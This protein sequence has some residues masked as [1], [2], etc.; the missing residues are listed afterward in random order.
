MRSS[1]S[2]LTLFD[3]AIY[4]IRVLGPLDVSWSEQLGGL[5]IVVVRAGDLAVT[6]LTGRL[7]DQA[8]LVSIITSLYDLGMPLLSVEWLATA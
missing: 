7:T 5:D 8:A 3:P 6:E 2:R 1:A 4:S